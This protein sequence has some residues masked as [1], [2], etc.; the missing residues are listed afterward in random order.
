MTLTELRYITAVARLRHFGR[1]AAACFVSQPTLS[2]AVKKLEEELGVAIFER[3]RNDIIV[4]AAGER[5][6]EQARRALEEADRVKEVARSQGDDLAMPLRLG[7]IYTVGPYLLPALVPCLRERAAGMQ[8]ILREDFT[9][10]LARALKSGELDVMVIALPYAQPGFELL[11]LYEEPFVL[12]LP[13]GHR[14]CSRDA[15]STDELAGETVLLL[16]AGNCFRDQVLAACPDC[17]PSGAVFEGPMQKTL[18]GG[19]LETIRLMVATGAGITVLPCMAA[20]G[21]SKPGGLLTIVPFSPP[22]PSR[23][24]ALAW[25][26][27][28]P[29]RAAIECLVEAIRACSLPCVTK[30]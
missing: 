3:R 22:P 6:V 1:A 28:F 2:I 10:N 20:A 18:E 21:D 27:S 23:T 25:R 29:R 8:L 15:V 7:A 11:P 17:D 13:A 12:A 5:I 4:T 9:G 16:S 19:S 24:V 30:P 14:W 26:R